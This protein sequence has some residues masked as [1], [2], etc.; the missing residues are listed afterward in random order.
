MGDA[1]AAAGFDRL[2]WLADEPQ[3]RAKRGAS[4]LAAWAVAAAVLIAGA[5]YW[6]GANSRREPAAAQP[7]PSARPSTTIPLPQ[8]RPPDP[9][10]R[11]D[12]APE[13]EPAVA[14]TVRPVP[15]PQVV[16]RRPE[17]RPAARASPAPRPAQIRPAPVART[18]PARPGL[19]PSKR[20]A[21]AAGRLVQIGAFATSYQA[22]R[23]WWYMVRAYPGVRRLPAVVVDSRNSRGRRFYRLQIGTSSQAHSEVLC[24]RM[25][26]IHYSCAVVGLPWK[27]RGVER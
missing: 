5:S 18:A 23:G 6:M 17:P 11:L 9:E 24:Q 14:P 20:S 13:V 2:P 7:P 25:E 3:P 26:K 10:V 4:E 21:G 27:P 19:W 12:R 22:K 15:E 1:R 16:I 8:A